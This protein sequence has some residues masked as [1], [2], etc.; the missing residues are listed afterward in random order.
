MPLYYSSFLFLIV[1]LYTKH[2]WFT[3][4]SS[5]SILHYAKQN[6]PSY[7]FKTCI[8]VAESIARNITVYSVFFDGLLWTMKQRD[9]LHVYWTFYVFWYFASIMMAPMWHM[10][11]ASQTARVITQQYACTISAIA[12]TKLKNH[13]I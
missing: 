2:P 13:S 9:S 7:P 4:L 5:V 10:R 6:E 1:G 8:Q 3:L 12:L 11:H